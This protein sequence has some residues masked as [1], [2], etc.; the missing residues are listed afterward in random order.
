VANAASGPLC[1]NPDIATA[2]T[3]L[4]AAVQCGGDVGRGA[5]ILDVPACADDQHHADRAFAIREVGCSH[6][7]VAAAFAGPTPP[8]WGLLEQ[9]VEALHGDVD[10]F[11]RL[12]LATGSSDA[13]P[14]DAPPST[15]VGPHQLPDRVDQTAGQLAP[16]RGTVSASR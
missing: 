10:T 13:R 4:S 6:T 2:A 11:H 16:G 7:T 3:E 14:P 5:H 1:A 9:I 12:R 15:A 8:R